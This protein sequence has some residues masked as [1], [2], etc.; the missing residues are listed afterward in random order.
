MKV[1]LVYASSSAV[2]GNLELGNDDEDNFDILSPY[3]Q[4]KMTLEE[5]AKLSWSLYKAPSIGLR[6]FNVYGPSARPH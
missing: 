4:D 1:P 3:A 6:F 2:Y 5:Y